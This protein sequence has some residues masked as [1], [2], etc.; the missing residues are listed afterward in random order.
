LIKGQNPVVHLFSYYNIIQLFYGTWL[1]VTRHLTTATKDKCMESRVHEETRA[2]GSR[3]T[4]Y[5]RDTRARG[6]RVMKYIQ[7]E[8]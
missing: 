8:A 1:A 4:K 6:T 3:V 7:L 5:T 2:Q